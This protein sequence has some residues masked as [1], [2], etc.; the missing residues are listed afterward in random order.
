MMSASRS[1][2][3]SARAGARR[4]RLRSAHRR[5]G[6][7]RASTSRPSAPR[8]SRRRPSPSGRTS[9][10]SPAR[11]SR[12]ARGGACCP[13]RSGARSASGR[14]PLEREAQVARLV[15]D[16]L[17]VAVDPLR[18]GA[19]RTS[20]PLARRPSRAPAAGLAC[21]AWSLGPVPVEHTVSGGSASKRRGDELDVLL[22]PALDAVDQHQRRPIASV[23][24]A[25]AAATSLA[26]AWSSRST[27]MSSS[28]SSAALAMHAPA[29]G[30]DLHL[31]V[32][33]DQVCGLEVGHRRV[34]DHRSRAARVG[35][36]ARP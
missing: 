7:P 34:L 4:G 2:R 19:R 36:P 16:P 5:A 3:S 18:R 28:T 14:V 9:R 11:A 29:P 30:V 31:V 25:I 26:G 8:R 6:R 33:L 10:S 1:R 32:A 35:R 20:P 23:I 24:A 13:R 21:G 12:V 15:D 27:S 22:L 17:T